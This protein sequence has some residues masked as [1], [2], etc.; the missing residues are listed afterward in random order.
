LVSLRRKDGIHAVA[1]DSLG[2]NLV[3]VAVTFVIFIAVLIYNYRTRSVTELDVQRYC[4][5]SRRVDALEKQA[6]ADPSPGNIAAAHDAEHQ[7]GSLMARLL[8]GA[9]V[10]CGP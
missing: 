10:P 8:G 5:Q 2:K 3:V 6:L 9:P 1:V 7:M 4:E